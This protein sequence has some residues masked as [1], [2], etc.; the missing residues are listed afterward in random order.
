MQLEQLLQEM[1]NDKDNI[2]VQVG[3]KQIE[4]LGSHQ[5]QSTIQVKL[6]LAGT[7]GSRAYGK[8]EKEVGGYYKGKINNSYR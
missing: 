7:A 6:P 4:I 3:Y 1:R 2:K 5:Y 8:A